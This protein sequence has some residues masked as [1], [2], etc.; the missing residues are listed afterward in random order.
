MHRIYD[1]C[2]YTDDLVD[3]STAEIELKRTRLASWREEVEACYHG[4]RM[5]GHGAS[6][7]ILRGLRMVL[8]HF[9]IPKEYLLA[10]IDG[11]EMDL[12]KTRYETFEE[13]REY[14]YA[15]ASTVGLISIQVFGYKHEETREYAIQLGYA[16]QLTNI[17]RDVKQDA[18]NGRIYL[19]REDLRAF[20][21]DEQS[22]LSAQYDERF[23]SLMQFEVSRARDYYSNA[24]SLLRK[25]ERHALFA[26]E[27]MDAI[28]F[29]L[30]HKIERAEYDVFSKRISVS[31]PHKLLIA[32]RFWANRYL[33]SAR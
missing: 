3:E 33:R 30:L 21:Y 11:V 27:I 25:D 10:L 13:L 2:R 18:A 16:L 12:V 14:C 7:P 9:E 31:A 22:L 1:F 4:T 20:G 19:P 15:V 32:F 17:L 23:I 24:R 29:R 5:I 28:Y 26:A 6:H 8:D